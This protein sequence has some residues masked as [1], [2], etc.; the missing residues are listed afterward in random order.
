MKNIGQIRLAE[1]MI[2]ILAILLYFIDVAAI[3]HQRVYRYIAIDNIDMLIIIIYIYNAQHD[4]TAYNCGLKHIAVV[5][6]QM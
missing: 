3:H 6:G 1:C 2:I 5:V 4:F